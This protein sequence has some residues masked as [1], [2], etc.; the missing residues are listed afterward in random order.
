[1]NGEIIKIGIG[2]L[3]R[4]EE[5]SIA[6]LMG[7]LGR[8]TLLSDSGVSVHAFV[9]PNGCTDRTADV[10]KQAF[11]QPPFSS[12]EISA[13]VHE[14]S[15]PG[16]SNAW[17]EFVHRIAP[18][19]I[20]Y[21]FFLD[22]DIRI[23]E[24]ES[25]KLML[26]SLRSSPTAVVAIDTSV[27]D[28]EIETPKSAVEW[29]IKACTGTAED[30]T[31]AI[32]GACYC[33]RFSELHDIWMPIGLPGED[34]YLRAMLLTSSFSHEERM[35]RHL[36]VPGAYHIFESHRNMRDVIQHNIR[37][38]IGTA[39]N[40]RLFWHIR[41]LRAQ[42]VNIAEYIRERNV[43]DPA[44]VN[45]LIRERLNHS[46]FPVGKRYVLRRLA[47][48]IR[49]RQWW[50]PKRWIIAMIGTAFDFLVFLKASFRMRKGAG[51]G[52]W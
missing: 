18:R 13:S 7:D 45:D 26:D 5:S 33:V 38:A 19:D 11:S 10:A 34:G 20:E 35:D 32:A 47:R 3:A 31:Q 12:P 46:F 42:G 28:I 24:R 44:W 39:V 17:N 29:L 25:L 16:K 9:I 1:M 43:A 4:N 48:V 51:A 27:K 21:V 50:S 23:P 14:L 37:L 49:D 6:D 36:F 30:K 2:I 15:V 41:D 40:A 22:A 52:Y 8:Q